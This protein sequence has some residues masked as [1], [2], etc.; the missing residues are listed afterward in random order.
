MILMG[1]QKSIR[2][3][4]Y[5]DRNEKQKLEE[6][7]GQIMATEFR[8]IFTATFESAAERDKFYTNIMDVLPTIKA[9]VDVTR[10]D[11]TKDSYEVNPRITEQVI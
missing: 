3:G 7:E 6:K 2:T 8:M 1:I 5:N 9:S 4:Q 10:A 11:M